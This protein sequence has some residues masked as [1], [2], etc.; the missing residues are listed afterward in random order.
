[1]IELLWIFENYDL[2]KVES[3]INAIINNNILS[4]NFKENVHICVYIS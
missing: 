4:D 3:G 1:M 2:F